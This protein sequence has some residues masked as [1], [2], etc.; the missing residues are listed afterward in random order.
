MKDPL[1]F[2][3][4]SCY[5]SELQWPG[6]ISLERVGTS[7]KRS[8]PFLPLLTCEL[9]SPAPETKMLNLCCS[10]SS[11]CLIAV[12]AVFLDSQFKQPIINL[13]SLEEEI[14]KYQKLCTLNND[15]SMAF[16]IPV[17]AREIIQYISGKTKCH[18][19]HQ[20]E[21]LSKSSEKKMNQKEQN[22]FCGLR[23]LDNKHSVRDT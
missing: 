5:F 10:F 19:H 1:Y 9:A 20:S 7:V 16:L 21:N 8:R 17:R 2:G 18:F 3:T 6:F 11:F 23:I 14:Q 22:F 13:I 4:G 15:S 12:W